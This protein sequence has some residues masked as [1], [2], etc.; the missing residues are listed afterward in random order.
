M[1]MLGKKRPARPTRPTAATT[2]PAPDDAAL[3]EHGVLIERL[4]H[5][6]RGVARGAD[7]KTLFVSGAL[8]GEHVEIAVHR[9]RKRFDEAHVRRWLQ[10]SPERATPPCPHYAQC[11]G[12]D[13]QHLALAAQ[14]RHKREVLIE[15]LSRQG[16]EL[17]EPP[18]LLAGAGLGYRRRARLGVKLDSDGDVHL[19]FRARA[20][21]HLVDIDSCTILVP[22]LEA[23]I[24]PLRE[25]LA[26]LDAP[27]HVGHLELLAGDRLRVVVVRQ[28]RDNPADAHAWQAWGEAH[29]VHVAWLVGRESPTWRWLGEPVELDYGLACN[30]LTGHALTCDERRLSLSYAPGDFLQINAEVNQLMVDTALDW[31]ALSGEERVLDLFAGVGNF[32]LPLALH[33][34]EVTAVE[35]S[36]A[37]VERLRDNARRNALTNVVACQADLAAPPDLEPR[38]DLVVLDPPREGAEAVCRALAASGIARVLYVACDPATLA[39]DAARLVRAGY[40]ISRTAVA[41]MFV[42]TAHLES[43]VLFER[44]ARRDTHR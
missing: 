1:A 44:D 11:G 34:A 3:P 43:L 42:Q 10:R 9:R 15:Q 39:R 4:S 18:S 19:G 16:I 35:G 24:A 23:L 32:S 6:G 25:Q 20:S 8:P 5:E 7:G 29:D 12:C 31:L 41:D 37:M 13:L 27:R 40:R 22:Q 21:H 33:A 28:L 38:P 14:R 26:S 36:P 30:G 2:A 17:A